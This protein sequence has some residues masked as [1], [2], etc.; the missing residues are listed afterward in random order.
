LDGSRAWRERE[1]KRVAARDAAIVAEWR[2][3][4]K[5]KMIAHMFSLSYQYVRYIIARSR[6]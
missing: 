1:R 5:M 3:G 6:K 2:R 4:T